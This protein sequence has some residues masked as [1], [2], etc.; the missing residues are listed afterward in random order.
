MD[1]RAYSAGRGAKKG[2][3]ECSVRTPERHTQEHKE[4]CWYELEQRRG[5]LGHTWKD[6]VPTLRRKD[7]ALQLKDTALRILVV[8]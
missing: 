6:E 7:I 5:R 2:V 4:K 8:T 3:L 1:A